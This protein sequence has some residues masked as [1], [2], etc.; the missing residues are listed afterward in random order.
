MSRKPVFAIAAATVL[1]VVVVS[2]GSEAGANMQRIR[3]LPTWT[4]PIAGGLVAGGPTSISQA[5]RSAHPTATAAIGPISV[6]G[7][8]AG[9]PTSAAQA[10]TAARRSSSYAG[11]VAGGPT[12]AAEAR[13]AARSPIAYG[14]LVAGGP[15]S[16]AQ[17][18][19]IVP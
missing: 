5:M 15:T 9:G 6:G 3:P 8:L 2:T 19:S 10:L 13:W 12:S 11:M 7:L 1:A 16:A 17:I 18:A 14:G 4:N